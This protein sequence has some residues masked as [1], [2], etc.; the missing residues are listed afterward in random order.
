[1]DSNHGS[2]CSV[3]EFARYGYESL[4]VITSDSLDASG[5]DYC[6]NAMTVT[7]AGPYSAVGGH[8]GGAVDQFIVIVFAG[9]K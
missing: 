9:L 5:L 1:M 7:F 8:D 6:L 4:N 2:F 3:N